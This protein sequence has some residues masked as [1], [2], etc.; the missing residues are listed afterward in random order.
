MKPKLLASASTLDDITRLIVRFYFG[1][2]ITLHE[3]SSGLYSVH[4]SS[5]PIAGVR[6]RVLKARY[7]FEQAT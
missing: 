7:R 4:N 1:T 5:G 6:V 2:P 3:S